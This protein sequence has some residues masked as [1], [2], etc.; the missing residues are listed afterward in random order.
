MPVP[1][2][3]FAETAEAQLP[4]ER[5]SDSGSSV[6]LVARCAVEIALVFQ[7]TDKY[8]EEPPVLAAK[9]CARRHRSRA[10]IAGWD[11]PG[12]AQRLAVI[13]LGPVTIIVK[14]PC[15]AG[16]I[17]TPTAAR[18]GMWMSRSWSRS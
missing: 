11:C 17:L 12:G 16:P 15:G 9:K 3:C 14:P 8:P 18:R 10:L 2:H 4:N 5:T 13:H 1:V 7:Y 6:S